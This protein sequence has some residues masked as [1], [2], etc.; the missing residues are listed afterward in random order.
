[1][2]RSKNKCQ[3]IIRRA[4]T[5]ILNQPTVEGLRSNKAI[6]VVKNAAGEDLGKIESGASIG[7]E[8]VSPI[9]QNGTTTAL[10]FKREKK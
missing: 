6:T 1:M 3:T 7:W 10:I 4:K 9:V 2:T 5:S 8:F